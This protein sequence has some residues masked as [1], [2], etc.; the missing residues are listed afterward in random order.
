MGFRLGGAQVRLEFTFA[1]VLC[2]LL[3]AFPL[4]IV[5]YILTAVLLHELGHLLCAAVFHVYPTRVVLSARG[6]GIT[7]DLGGL[8]GPCR[9]AVA[10]AGPAVNLCMCVPAALLDFRLWAIVNGIVGLLNLIP[11][12]GLDGG[13]LL[14]IVLERRFGS[15]AAEKVC[16]AV[17]GVVLF[18]TAAAYF[19]LLLTGMISRRSLLVFAYLVVLLFAEPVPDCQTSRKML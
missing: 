11:I 18:P 19:L 4:S 5:L 9:F 10:L 7:M 6:V 2:I 14:Q 13:D 8:S 15:A 17:G 1:A 3:V 12:P 16:L